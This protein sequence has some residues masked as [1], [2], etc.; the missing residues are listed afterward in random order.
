MHIIAQDPPVNLFDAV[1]AYRENQMPKVDFNTALTTIEQGKAWIG[2]LEAANMMFH[3]EDSPESIESGAT[4]KPLFTKAEAEA[5]RARIDELYAMDWTVTGHECPIGYALEAGDPE[6]FAPT[7]DR[8]AEEFQSYL[9]VYNL[10]Q[11]TA[12][13]LMVRENLPE[14]ARQWLSMFI[15]RRVAVEGRAV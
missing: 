6:N 11:M 3:F 1:M 9:T 13:E 4:G 10:P 12:D 15:R 5:V 2:A 14:R 7:L 8:M